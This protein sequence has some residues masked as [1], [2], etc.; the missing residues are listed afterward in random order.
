MKRLYIARH[1]KSS[2]DDPSLRDFDRPLNK[3]G[4]RDAPFMAGVMACKD[5][6]PELILTSPALR[7]KT[8]A[9]FYRRYLG[10]TLRVDERIYDASVSTLYYVI[11]EAFETY[12]KVMIVG[13]NPG[14]T[15]LDAYLSDTPVYHIPTAGIV[16]MDFPKGDISARKGRQRF[17]IY[18]K[19]FI[20]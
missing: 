10:G 8:T 9:E 12:Q 15:E 6:R 3:R 16:A 4:L 14:L 1:A 7:A 19:A 13:H 18:P 17:F 20:P 5:E 2:W 11:L